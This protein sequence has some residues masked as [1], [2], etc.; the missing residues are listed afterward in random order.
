MIGWHAMSGYRLPPK[1]PNTGLAV[2]SLV[3]VS[4][5]AALGMSIPNV[6]QPLIS[7]DFE[8]SVSAT[9][10]VSL[11][12]L[13]LSSLLMVPAGRLADSLGRVK[14]LLG[15]IGIFTLASLF[16]GFATSLPLLAV[17]R[18]AMGIGGAAMTALPVALVRQTVAPDRVGRT[19]GVIGSA[20]AAGWALGPAAGGMLAAVAGW[21]LAFLAL[22]PLGIA[23]LAM[24]A[25]ALPTRQGGTGLALETD[26]LGSAVLALALVSYSVG[27]T[28]RPFGWVGTVSLVSLGV[29]SLVAFVFVELRV[30]NPLV[31]F[32]LLARVRVYPGLITAFL[33]STIMMSFTV[34]PPFYLARGL[35]LD[36]GQVGLAMAVGPTVS[37]L[38]GVPAGRLVERFG[39]KPIFVTGLTFLTVASV[40]FVTLPAALG[41]AGFFISAVTLTPGNQMFMA[42]NNTNVMAKSGI[43][44]Q[45]SVAGILSLYRNL[46][47]ITGVAVAAA[48]FDS[49]VE[50]VPGTGGATLGLQLSFGI[51]A[52]MGVL[53]LI[54][55]FTTDRRG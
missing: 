46:G 55:A 38:S 20:M 26:L 32:R 10:W 30:P 54:I 12:Y 1:V 5:V 23:A 47:S 21:R 19:M 28:L 53:A 17:A 7:D 42:A 13:L 39:S 22:V 41:L 9:Q 37:V 14:V 33:A 49:A 34:I 6:A 31:D 4:T 50:R 3:V 18:G 15:G 40:G 35:E 27:L 24:V 2:A 45:G 44:H 8:V 52:V 16:A 29:A 43:A 25:K 11:S 36:A 51:A 48:L